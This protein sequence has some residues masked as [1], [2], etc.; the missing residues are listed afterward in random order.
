MKCALKTSYTII[1]SPSISKMNQFLTTFTLTKN[2][3]DLFSCF[4]SSTGIKNLIQRG[5]LIGFL[6]LKGFFLSRIFL[7]KPSSYR[8]SLWLVFFLSLTRFLRKYKQN[9]NPTRLVGKLWCLMSEAREGITRLLWVMVVMKQ[10]I[11]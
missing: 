9:K 7:T 11:T 2:Y 1:Y 3:Q 6:S 5:M 4:L 10:I 8:V